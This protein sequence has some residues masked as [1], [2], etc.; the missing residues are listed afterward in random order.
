MAIAL[1]D[2]NVLVSLAW[3][4]Q[5]S[6]YSVQ[7]WFSKQVRAGWATTAVTQSGFIRTMLNPALG[8]HLSVSAVISLL[9][10]ST[11]DPNHHCWSADCD[12]AE[13][14]QPFSRHLRGY[15]QV[16]D[17]FLIGLAARH[18]GVL[19]TLDGGAA[20]LAK[21]AGFGHVVELLIR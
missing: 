19:A 17:A 11:S 3:P 1:L 10:Q 9:E 14:L 12:V 18:G 7:T 15:R 5:Q 21:M 16:T 2:V 13:I 20:E 4:T 6:S 8:P